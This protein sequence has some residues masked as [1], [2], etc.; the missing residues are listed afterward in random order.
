MNCSD[1]TDSTC[2]LEVKL[3]KTGLGLTCSLFLINLEHRLVYKIYAGSQVSTTSLSLILM[4]KRPLLTIFSF[5]KFHSLLYC[6]SPLF[7]VGSVQ[8]QI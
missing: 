5:N 4:L 8:V 7:Y 6:F 3:E 2:R 1:E